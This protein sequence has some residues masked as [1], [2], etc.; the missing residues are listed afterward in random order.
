MKSERMKIVGGRQKRSR[1]QKT[2]KKPDNPAS[3]LPADYLESDT[4]R[5][6]FD[7]LKGHLESAALIYKV[8]AELLNVSVVWLLIFDYYASQMVEFMADGG[9]NPFEVVY[10]TGAKGVS[11]GYSVMNT[12]TNQVQACFKLLGIGPYSRSKIKEFLDQAQDKQDEDDP[13]IKAANG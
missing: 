1:S 5:A 13:F 2:I 6:K 4:A 3:L 7:S 12:A 9:S 11:V 10:K 8:D